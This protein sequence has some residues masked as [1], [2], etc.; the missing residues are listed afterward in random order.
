MEWRAGALISIGEDI[1]RYGNGDTIYLIINPRDFN[2][3][4]WGIGN[5]KLKLV[6]VTRFKARYMQRC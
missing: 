1:I 4:K 2:S 3:N 5:M 6:C